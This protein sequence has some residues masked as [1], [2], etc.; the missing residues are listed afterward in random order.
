MAE[1]EIMYFV[2]VNRTGKIR[3]TLIRSACYHNQSLNILPEK[4][5]SISQATPTLVDLPISFL[6]FQFRTSRWSCPRILWA[7]CLN[8]KTIWWDHL[9]NSFISKLSNSLLY[10]VSILYKI[11]KS[12]YLIYLCLQKIQVTRY[13]F[14][15]HKYL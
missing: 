9:P 12:Q 4:N 11:Y 8:F 7:R 6:R 15:A 2:L 3:A 5:V 13:H 14:R 10:D 1:T